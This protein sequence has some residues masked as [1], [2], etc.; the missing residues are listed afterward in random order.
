[1]RTWEPLINGLAKEGREG[2]KKEMKKGKGK[3]K[4]DVR[5]EQMLGS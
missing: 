2:G 5:E 3:G 4:R 1:M